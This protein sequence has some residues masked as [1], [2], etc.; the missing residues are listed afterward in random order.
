MSYDLTPAEQTEWAARTKPERI[1]TDTAGALRDPVWR[2][3][4]GKLYQCLN[5]NGREVPFI[6]TPEQRLVIWSIVVRGWRRLIIPKARQLGMSLVLCIIGLDCTAFNSGFKAALVDKTEDDARKKLTEKVKFALDRLPKSIL[7][8]LAIKPTANTLEIKAA[9]RKDEASEPSSRY[10]ADVSFRGG[11]VEFLHISEWGEVQ[12][13]Q[14]ERSREIR[15]GSLPAVERA[16]D[17]IC[18]I[19]TTWQGGLDGELGPLVIEA[20]A[21]PEAQKVAKSWRILF[22]PW[23][24]NPDYCQ[25]H[26]YIDEISAKYFRDCEKLG[27]TLTHPQKLWF[28]EKRRTTGTVSMKS[29]FPTVAHECWESVP[30]GSIYGALVEESRAAGRIIAYEPAD[31]AVDTYW[32]IG[33][34]VNTVC[35]FVQPVG[36]ELHVLDVDMARD[37]TMLDRLKSYAARGYPFGRHHLPHDAGIVLSSGRNQAE[38]FRADMHAA[39]ITGSVVIVPR[40][41]DEWQGIDALKLAW[42]RLVFRSP[43][44]D[45]GLLHLT[46]FRAV[47]ETNTGVSEN[48]TVHDRYSHAASALRQLGQAMNIGSTAYQPVDVGFNPYVFGGGNLE[49]RGLW[50]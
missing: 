50:S 18:V 31:L 26:G 38:D 28:A 15:D 20:Q 17:G 11:T 22:F 12:L 14:R 34:P 46:R 9:A 16:A 8:T 10:E 2:L 23:Y 33:N 48:T 35:W 32:D 13:K 25:G 27:I 24:C 37:V 29:Q 4:S 21:T 5:Q 42:P 1:E 44:C 7:A 36:P 43:T 39:G 49:E 41:A 3:G 6:P 45:Q 19:E 30:E 47:A 40:V